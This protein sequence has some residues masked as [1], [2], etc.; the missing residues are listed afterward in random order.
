MVNEK[1]PKYER[2]KI[3][4]VEFDGKIGWVMG[5]RRDERF[6]LRNKNSDSRLL[7]IHVTYCN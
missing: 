4:L 2:D 7:K 5:Y 3:G 6:M 1:I